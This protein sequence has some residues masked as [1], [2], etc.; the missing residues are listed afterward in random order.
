MSDL[1]A[2][3]YRAVNKLI[4]LFEFQSELRHVRGYFHDLC[5]T[6]VV[7]VANEKDEDGREW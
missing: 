1:T 6:V 2:T 3:V 5:P 4:T 7:E